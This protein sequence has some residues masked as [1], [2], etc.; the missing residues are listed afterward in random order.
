MK[1]IISVLLCFLMIMPLSI[2][3]FAQNNTLM[4]SLTAKS[5]VLM[6]MSSG[7]ILLSKNPDENY[8]LRLLQKL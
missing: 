3:A 1:K 7:E 6:E 4:D 5:V 8:H 2:T